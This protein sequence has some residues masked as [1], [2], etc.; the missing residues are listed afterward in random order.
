MFVWRTWPKF[1][2]GTDPIELLCE[3]PLSHS[4]D[5]V[6]APHTAFTFEELGERCEYNKACRVLK[7]NVLDRDVRGLRTLRHLF[8][9]YL[10]SFLPSL[11]D[12][13]MLVFGGILLYTCFV[14]S[15]ELSTAQVL[16][17]LFS[18]D[19]LPLLSPHQSN[20][21]GSPGPSP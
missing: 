19:R 16:I 10:A 13:Q 4:S 7:S 5:R 2:C 17:R 11:R 15:C 6:H 1:H 14:P 12:G 20:I 21:G 3:T 18:I 8:R 9:K